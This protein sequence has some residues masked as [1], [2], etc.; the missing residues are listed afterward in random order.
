[1]QNWDGNGIMKV[2]RGDILLVNL[3]PTK[4]SEQGDI[5]PTLV[6]QNN[7]G[8][9]FSPTTIVLPITSKKYT[10]EF[11]TNVEILRE[12]SKLKMD[13]TILANQIRTIDKKRI[14]R[15]ISHLD[16]EVMSKVDL[17]LRISL[18]ME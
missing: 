7:F 13:S 10:K 5:R 1:M 9:K 12:E 18:G 14:I 3:N 6:I 4:G 11:S 15:K 17:A 2:N 8:N 16:E